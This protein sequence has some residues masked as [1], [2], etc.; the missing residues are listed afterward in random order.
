ML[1]ISFPFRFWSLFFMVVSSTFLTSC[2]RT[3]K[4]ARIIPDDIMFASRVNVLRSTYQLGEWKKMLRE[5]FELDLQ[6]DSISKPMFLITGKGYVFGEVMQ[7]NKNF[8]AFSIPLFNKR[9]FEKFIKKTIPN[10]PIKVYKNYK[11]IVKNKNIFAWARNILLLIDANQSGNEQ[12]AEKLFQKITETPKSKSL[13]L[14]NQNFKQA[15]KNDKDVALWVNM[16]RFADIPEVKA[17]VKNIP[18]KNNFLHV[19]TNFDEGIITANSEYFT[20]PEIYDSYKNVFSGKINK[21]LIENIP[22]SKP[23]FVI[24]SG[25]NPNELKVLLKD[26]EWTE[27]AENLVSSLT[28]TMEQFLEMISGEI[29]IA[30]KKIDIETLPDSLKEDKKYTADVVVGT[31]IK[32][33]FVYDSLIKNLEASGAL[34]KKQGYSIFLSELFILQQDSLIYITKNENIKNDFINNV[35]LEN[36]QVLEQINNKWFTFYA[37]ESISVRKMEGKSLVNSIA[38]TLIKSDK[39]KLESATFHLGTI[40]KNKK[41]IEGETIVLLKD[42]NANALWSMLEVLKEILFQTKQ[43]FDPNFFNENEK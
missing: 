36:K 38:K 17:F 32:N 43:R 28:L 14:N 30:T 3:P 25:I 41:H 5:E 4:A 8:T 24:S 33:F 20:S 11:Y 18:F 27:K 2:V 7:G 1:S 19:Q 13:I 29:T 26:I 22:I 9:N 34:E 6:A 37:D 23:S 21:R 31:K 35:K 16:D 42:K 39:I 10:Q 15:L 40:T 12:E